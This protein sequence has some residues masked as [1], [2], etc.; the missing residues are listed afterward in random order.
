M[1]IDDIIEQVVA[2]GGVLA[3]RPGR[4]D[5]SPE[6]AWGDVFLYYAPDGEVPQTQPFATIVTKDYPGDDTSRLDRADTFRVNVHVGSKRFR[7]LV[8]R[9]PGDWAEDDVDPSTADALFPHPVY[10]HLGWVAVV[11]PADRTGAQVIELLTAAHDD[12]RARY[13]RR[14]EVAH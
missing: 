6:I 9:D 2:L 13:A 4:G 3:L 7:E 11:N 14:S 8:G 10:G 5:G 1:S 12:A